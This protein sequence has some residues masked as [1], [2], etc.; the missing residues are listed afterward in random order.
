MPHCVVV[1]GNFD[2][3]HQGHR[4]LLRLARE[5][6]REL[7]DNGHDLPVIA[8]TLWPHPMTIFAADRAP[9]LLTTLD[10]RLAL[11]KLYGA[12]EVRVIQFNREVAS[13]SPEH[14]VDTMV[15]PLDPAVVIVGANF[16]FGKG[17]RGTGE[18]LRELSGGDFEVEN[19]GLVSVGG[20]KT[21]SSFIRRTLAAGDVAT[22]GHH[23]GRLFRVGGVVMVGDQRG[24]TLGFPTANLAIDSALATPGD[25]VYAG[26]LTLLDDP[27]VEPMEAAI[28]VGTN[29]TFDGV[30]RRVES[31]VIDRTGLRLYGRRIAVDFVEHLRGML[32]FH[33]VD[34]LITQ[35]H[36]DVA[37]T[38][39]ILDA[40]RVTPGVTAAPDM[41]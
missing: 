24:H 35:M 3:V 8:L 22:A 16:T 15:R 31:N 26:W 39:E 5:R 34:E 36:T 25:G 7:G 41:A 6:A 33:D 19:L 37:R 20:R 32:R 12:D 4:R 27:D 17:A 38:R 11:L 1:I 23:L 2:G 9:R 10:D 30:E 40:P 29:P 13:W 18:T 21:S 28:S 14:F